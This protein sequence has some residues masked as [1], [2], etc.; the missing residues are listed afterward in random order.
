MSINDHFDLGR[1][2][3]SGDLECEGCGEVNSDVKQRDAYAGATR[4]YGYEAG[5][6]GEYIGAYNLC[7]N[8]EDTFGDKQTEAYRDRYESD[9][10]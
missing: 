2:S 3:A 8:C 4:D 9:G 10:V 6:P 1:N 5:D 7:S